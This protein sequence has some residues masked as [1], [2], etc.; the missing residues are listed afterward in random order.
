MGLFSFL[1]GS[2]KPGA[3]SGARAVPPHM[4][5]PARATT[6]QPKPRAT[7]SPAPGADAQPGSGKLLPYT[8]D[9]ERFVCNT[10]S[11]LIA[12]KIYFATFPEVADAY[13]KDRVVSVSSWLANK[14]VPVVVSGR[15]DTLWLLVAPDFADSDDLIDIVREARRKGFEMHPEFQVVVVAST[16]LLA[17]S[18]GSLGGK[19][20]NQRRKIEG[21]R[22]SAALFEGFKNIIDWA[23]IEGAA[24]VDFRYSRRD[25]RSLVG[26]SIGGKWVYPERFSM[27]SQTMIQMLGLAFQYGEGASEPSLDVLREQQLRIHLRLPKAGV[28]VMLR[29]ASMAGDEMVAVTCR[30]IELNRK[31]ESV[32]LESLGY[33][34]SQQHILHRALNSDGGAVILSGVVNSGK[35]TTIAT[36]MGTVPKTRKIVT[37]EDPVEFMIPGVISNTVARPLTGEASPILAAKLRTLKRTGFNDLLLGEIRDRETGAAAQDVFE[38]GQ[39][40]YSTVHTGRAWMIPDRLAGQS[41]GIPREVL[42]TPGNLRLLVNQSLIPKNCDHCKVPFTSLLSGQNAQ[43]HG[44]WTAYAD[45]LDRLY[46]LDLEKVMI[47]N[48]EGCSRCRRADMPQLNGFSGR[49]SASEMIEPDEAFCRLVAKGDNV[50]ILHYLAD[51]RGGT[52]YDDPNMLGKS[53]MDCAVY[54]MS[55]GMIDP[56]EIEPRYMDFETVEITR[57]NF[58]G[59]RSSIEPTG[60]GRGRTAPPVQLAAAAQMPSAG[61]ATNDNVRALAV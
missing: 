56:R 17:I 54:K 61:A 30:L 45:R 9:G 58:R 21:N 48:E 29:W 18:R 35:S 31:I 27:P 57:E 37:I 51:I 20:M 59:A 24:D 40:L 1:S 49:T 60:G 3:R 50:G 36:L 16:V 47:R 39:K 34:P 53:S 28:E 25:E 42:A 19:S 55:I 41:I 38:S 4:K 5:G 14:V 6:A 10:D 32:S 26:F 15:K 43:E 23:Y 44:R 13:P 12:E 7:Q 2:K 33:L 8:K 52:R 46:D 22:E 11:D